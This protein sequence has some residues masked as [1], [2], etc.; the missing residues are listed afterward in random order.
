MAYPFL[1]SG[2]QFPHLSKKTCP[3]PCLC[4]CRVPY[5]VFPLPALS[6]K[7]RTVLVVCGPEQNGAVGL[8]CARHLRVFVSNRDAFSFPG[9]PPTLSLQKL[10]S[11]LDVSELAPGRVCCL[12]PRSGG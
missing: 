6:R 8:V 9:L 12:V 2:P 11:P 7:Q 10:L 1:N 5:Q 4:L 3:V